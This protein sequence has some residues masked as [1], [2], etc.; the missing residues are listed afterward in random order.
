MKDFSLHIKKLRR[1][2]GLTQHEL[3]QKL[4]VLS[5]AVSSWEQG[6]FTPSAENYARLAVLAP[7][8]QAWFFLGKLELTQEVLHSKW[9]AEFEPRP[10]HESPE[11]RTPRRP[12]SESSAHSE[13]LG[14]LGGRVI[15]IRERAERDSPAHS[16]RPVLQQAATGSQ[17]AL[18]SQAVGADTGADAPGSTSGSAREAAFSPAQRTR[19]PL[20]SPDATPSHKNALGTPDGFAP[21]NGHV[22]SP[23]EIRIYTLPEWRAGTEDR[24]RFQI[25]IPVLRDEAAAGAPRE[26]NER[27][28]D[29]FI[30]IPAKFVPK[31]PAAYTGIYIRGDSMEPILRDRFI[32]VVDHTN[33]DPGRLRGRMVAALVQD[34][35]LVKWLARESRSDRIILRSQNPEYEDIL[36]ESPETDP[37][38]GDVVFWWGAQDRA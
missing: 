10:A 23:P 1:S 4:G 22:I 38:I 29:S 11:L 24:L 17:S 20:E 37:I 34:G 36:I 14:K 6:R 5:W 18:I 7:P 15:R 33:R 21:A 3:A 25:Q 27:D 28:I 30:A 8:E 2:L 26:I 16:E 9:P 35:V 13:P 32:V 31:G 12:R 19:R